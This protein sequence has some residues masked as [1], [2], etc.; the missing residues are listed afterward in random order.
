MGFQVLLDLI[1]SAVV[2]GLFILSLL[3]F[4]AQN[5]ETKRAFRDEISAF[6]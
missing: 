4:S 1:G 3:S 5:S 2:G 6:V